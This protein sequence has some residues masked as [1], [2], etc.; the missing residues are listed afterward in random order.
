[1]IRLTTLHP[2]ND[3]TQVPKQ[4]WP[5]ELDNVAPR[6]NNYVKVECSTQDVPSS[7]ETSNVPRSCGMQ[8]TAN[9]P[10][11]T[12]PPPLSTYQQFKTV[13]QT[14]F[15]AQTQCSQNWHDRNE[16]LLIWVPGAQRL[17]ERSVHIRGPKNSIP[18]HNSPY[19]APCLAVRLD[20]RLRLRYSEW[21]CAWICRVCTSTTLPQGD[22]CTSS[23]PPPGPPTNDWQQT[24]ESDAQS[25]MDTTAES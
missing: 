14:V 11:S 3:L 2:S 19:Y 7:P 10:C 15:H 9:G 5:A 18:P 22:R 17:L 23:A 12:A 8:A 16:L 6:S 1:M 4:N 24:R 20:P 21:L 13:R 25:I